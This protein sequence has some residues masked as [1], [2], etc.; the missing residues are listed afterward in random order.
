[1]DVTVEV[2]IVS[3]GEFLEA[4]MVMYYTVMTSNIHGRAGPG[5]FYRGVAGG[6]GGGGGG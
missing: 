4:S 5:M 3:F 1:M 6:G 2:K